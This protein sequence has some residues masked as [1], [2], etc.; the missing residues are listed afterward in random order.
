VLE[1]IQRP[2][3][4]PY[5]RLA[6]LGIMVAQLKTFLKPFEYHGNIAPRRF[7]GGVIYTLKE[8]MDLMMIVVIVVR[9]QQDKNGKEARE[10]T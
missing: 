3:V 2:C 10:E 6:P 9:W 8:T 4:Q 5:E 7:R 1:I